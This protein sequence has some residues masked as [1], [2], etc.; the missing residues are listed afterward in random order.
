MLVHKTDLITSSNSISN[1]PKRGVAL[2]VVIIIL[3]LFLALALQLMVQSNSQSRLTS[4]RRLNNIYESAA[5]Y[6][7][8]A[9]LSDI[10]ADYVPINDLLST[11]EDYNLAE[12]RFSALTTAPTAAGWESAYGV[13]YRLNGVG[14]PA[15]LTAT[16][17]GWTISMNNNRIDIPVRVFV[18]NNPDDISQ[19]IAG[20]EI[21]EVPI[22]R[23]TDLDGRIVV[24]AIAYRGEEPIAILSG[25]LSP[26][27]DY[28]TQTYARAMDNVDNTAWRN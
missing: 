12:T 13:D 20:S 27:P 9:V 24:T 23:E 10:S 16:A 3:T 5:E 1:T 17:D 8:N 15:G 2:F 21:D 18:K 6:A 28:G 19:A 7:L 26:D 4:S 22:T 11:S 25:T 14:T